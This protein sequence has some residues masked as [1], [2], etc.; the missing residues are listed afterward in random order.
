MI[1]NLADVKFQYK[2]KN[3]RI[4]LYFKK[5]LSDENNICEFIQFDENTFSE[6]N[7][8]N[9]YTLA[10]EY[11]F[12]S[13]LVK[14]RLLNYN[15]AL[16]HGVA[17]T[18]NN[19]AFII[20]ADSGVGKTTQY[21]NLKTLFKEEI[22]ILN[23][24]KPILDFTDAGR[25]QIRQSPWMGKERLYSHRSAT[26]NGIIVLSQSK[27]NNIQRM[28]PTDAG[29]YFLGQ[30]FYNALTP[31]QIEIVCQMSDRLVRTLPVWYFQNDGTVDSSRLLY[32]TLIEYMEADDE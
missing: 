2:E 1:I 18:I 32:D 6:F 25:I 20:T 14:D 5:F 31:N 8:G 29:I 22:D 30:F 4:S 7:K 11:F 24:D 17:F 10:K 28:S 26:L 9:S 15:K 13:E 19:K 12:V 3:E 23:G 16:F 27:T 21:I